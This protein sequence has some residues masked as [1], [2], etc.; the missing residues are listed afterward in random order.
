[1]AKKTSTKKTTG[2]KPVAK[3]V[4]PAVVLVIRAITTGLGNVPD[5]P[6]SL[7]DARKKVMASIDRLAKRIEANL[8]GAGKKTVKEAAARV[9]AE[10]KTKRDAGRRAKKVAARDALVKK[11]AAMDADL[12][13]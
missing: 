11:L 4:V 1:M 9:R 2:S 10:A 7:I 5:V 13:A 6:K 12:K 8:A 3:P